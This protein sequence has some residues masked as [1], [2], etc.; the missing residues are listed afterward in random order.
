[1][2]I[3]NKTIYKN[4]FTQTELD[5]RKKVFLYL[6]ED[7]LK[8]YIPENSVVLDLASGYCEF[9]NVVKADTKLAL[10]INPDIKHH[11]A[12]DVEVLINDARNMTDVENNSI[13]I[14][15][16][17]NFF[18]HISREDILIV[19][20][21]I[22]RILRP[23]GKFLSLHPNFRH[24]YKD[25]FMYF[26]HMTP[27]DDKSYVEALKLHDF[28]IVECLPKTLPYTIKER[29]PK[30]PLLLRVYLKMPILHKVFGKQMFVC[31]QKV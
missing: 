7:F 15:F 31:A 1:M 17:S 5:F 11:A 23:G 26:D 22:K 6:Y 3:D 4:R 2:D 25:Y 14:V 16:V 27:L 18:E 21:E 12:K 8:R 20:G 30:I 29:I 24:C 19:L 10:D 9:I 13:D 28:D